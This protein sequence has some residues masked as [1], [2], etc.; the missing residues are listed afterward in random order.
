[1]TTEGYLQTKIRN[2]NQEI[3]KI[4]SRF[5]SLK[6]KTDKL[7]E[8][9][10]QIDIKIEL[11]KSIEQNIIS[12]DIVKFQDELYRRIVDNLKESMRGGLKKNGNLMIDM[13]KRKLD[14][15]TYPWIYGLITD[16]TQKQMKVLNQNQNIIRLNLN[17]FI[18]SKGGVEMPEIPCS[19]IFDNEK[20]VKKWLKRHDKE[21]KF[22]H[23]FSDGEFSS[24]CR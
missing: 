8:I 11:M 14:N 2:L 5:D 19:P 6:N 12:K 13:I 23:Q 9:K 4:E 1:M 20:D 16:L 10:K 17:D 21:N 15:E 18:K 24:L 22:T 7:E 3:E